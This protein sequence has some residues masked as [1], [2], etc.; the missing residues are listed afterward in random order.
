MLVLSQAEAVSLE[1]L[2]DLAGRFGPRVQA[3]VAQTLEGL[4]V[5]A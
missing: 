2:R 5:L 1:A 3:V 4:E